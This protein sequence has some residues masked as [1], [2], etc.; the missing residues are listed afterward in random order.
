[1]GRGKAAGAQPALNF[2]TLTPDL[3]RL[4]PM[5]QRVA[6]HLLSR[7]G[8]WVDAHDL[9][10]IGGFAAWRTRI[11]ECRRELERQGLGTIQNEQRREGRYRASFYRYEAAT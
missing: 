10:Q 9:L 4:G 8:T 2:D 3:S 5:A 6:Q 11:S 1:M 7:P